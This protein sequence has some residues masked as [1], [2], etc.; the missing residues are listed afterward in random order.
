MLPYIQSPGFGIYEPEDNQFSAVGGIATWTKNYSGFWC[1]ECLCNHGR[2]T[3][4]N[5]SCRLCNSWFYKD[6]PVV[7]F[8]MEWR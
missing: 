7:E 6:D 4:I 8:I 1:P 3:W 5:G 2:F